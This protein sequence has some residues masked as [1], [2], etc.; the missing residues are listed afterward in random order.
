MPLLALLTGIFLFVTLLAANILQVLSLLIRPVS[1]RAFRRANRAI[2]HCWWGLCVLWTEHL[3]RIRPIF[4]GD[5]VA[6]G[7]NAIVI[8]NH[9]QMP[10]IIALM[11]LAWRKQRLGDMKWFVK[12]VIKY[13]PGIGWGM[14]FLDCLFLKREW[15]KDAS[16]VKATFDKFLEAGI[17]VWLV[18]FPEGT[19]ITLPK[20]ER[21]RE[22]AKKSGLALPERVLIPRA[23]GFSSSVIG[24][25]RHVQAVYD[26]TIAYPKR[27]PTLWQFLNTWGAEVHLHVRRYPIAVLPKDHAGLARWIQARFVE[28][29]A[30]LARF[31]SKGVL[32]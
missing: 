23:R 22:F 29:D 32:Q 25:G 2:A 10:D 16:R 21:A 9:Q 31:N 13:V 24:L 20:L 11:M 27:P 19:R 5:N 3:H 7:E 26:V 12:D 8:A 28:K 14:L 1:L 4:T 30:M 18:S 6:D 17:P 15:D